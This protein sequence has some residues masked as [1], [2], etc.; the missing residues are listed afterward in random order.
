MTISNIWK[1]KNMFQATNQLLSE[2]PKH[3]NNPMLLLETLRMSTPFED[4]KLQVPPTH[5]KQ[6]GNQWVWKINRLIVQ[7]ANKNLRHSTYLHLTVYHHD[8]LVFFHRITYLASSRSLFPH[9]ETLLQGPRVQI[10]I[11]S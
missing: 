5:Q 3:E 10:R 1:H 8:H 7:S 9:I 4:I 11:W 2:Y 6:L